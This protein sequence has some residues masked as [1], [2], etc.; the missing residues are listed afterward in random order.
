MNLV[1]L[2]LL[3][4]QQVLGK[5]DV[6]DLGMGT[7]ED[8]YNDYGAIINYLDAPD[9]HMQEI[10]GNN[11]L[12]LKYVF[13]S[14]EFKKSNSITSNVHFKIVLPT[15]KEMKQYVR[16]YAFDCQDERIQEMIDEQQEGLGFF[17][18]CDPARNPQRM[19]L[20]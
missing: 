11:L 4:S 18:N 8:A 6:R 3:C 13:D 14:E 15:L 20:L 9:A 17:S 1:T 2:L 16:F 5:Y 19:P 12:S 7:A 10:E